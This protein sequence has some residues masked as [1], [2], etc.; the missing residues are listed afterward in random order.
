MASAA[1][2]VNANE[3]FSTS[4]VNTKW[5]VGLQE[6]TVTYTWPTTSP[7]LAVRGYPFGMLS[8][9]GLRAC[10]SSGVHY[11]SLVEGGITDI[12]TTSLGVF[13][14]LQLLYLDYNNLSHVKKDWFSTLRRPDALVVLSLSHNKIVDIESESFARLGMLR[15]MSLEHNR[16]RNLH[17]D[18]FYG[19][20]NLT[21]LNLFS[22]RLET[23]TKTAFVFLT[24]LKQLNMREN[25]LLNLPKGF[26]WPQKNPMYLLTGTGLLGARDPTFEWRGVVMSDLSLVQISVSGLSTYSTH[27]DKWFRYE[28]RTR[29]GTRLTSSG[30]GIG[31]GSLAFSQS[32]TMEEQKYPAPFLIIA[33]MEGEDM[34]SIEKMNYWCE[35]FWAGEGTVSVTLGASKETTVQLAAVVTKKDN[36]T[37]T[38]ISVLFNPAWTPDEE[39][40]YVNNQKQANSTGTRV[41]TCVMLSEMNK[42]ES[43]FVP[44][45][46]ESETV[47]VR[48]NVS[49]QSWNN[50]T[51][52]NKTNLVRDGEPIENSTTFHSPVDVSLSLRPTETDVT[53]TVR[54]ELP[55]QDEPVLSDGMIFVIIAGI[56]LDAVVTTFVVRMLVKRRCPS[57]RHDDG[58][59]DDGRHDY[60]NDYENTDISHVY[61][62][63]PDV[64]AG[65]PP[66][67]VV[68][69]TRGVGQASTSG[70]AEDDDSSYSEIPDDYF[71]FN[72]P[73]YRY[74]RNSLPPDD[75]NYWQILDEFYGY[76][77]TDRLANWRPSSLPLTFEA[78]YENAKY[79]NVGRWQRQR[80]DID[81]TPMTGKVGKKAG[82]I[83]RPIN[84]DT[85]SLANWRPSS[86]PLTLEATYENVK[87]ENVGRWSRQPSAVARGRPTTKRQRSRDVIVIGGYG[88]ESR[89]STVESGDQ[90]MA[91]RVGWRVRLQER[92]NISYDVAKRF[93]DR[94]TSAYQS[95]RRVSVSTVESG[96][97]NM[98][99]RV[100]WRVRLQ[101]RDNTSYDVAKRFSDR[102]TSAYQTPRVSV[103]SA[104]LDRAL[105]KQ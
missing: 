40:S 63:I 39:S 71:S 78:T 90:N 2:L 98:A 36:D 17:P 56:F 18:W 66:R 95:P 34:A 86:L 69:D 62:E 42:S 92:D 102:R 54:P 35:R 76:E 25:E 80:S 57:R 52:V 89:S 68:S 59:H 104:L 21:G 28:T 101:E 4:S 6:S 53:V 1:G 11:L 91:A 97:Q 79:E 45:R 72:N 67:P 99:A 75:H 46:G 77:N 30:F 12:E 43:Y 96:G 26:R 87:Y 38:L 73:G 84:E 85:E 103:S 58:R 88:T 24:E 22:N 64:L 5:S 83:G 33:A 8:A 41:V 16:L 13:L 37:T 82:A 3:P 50:N 70:T 81:Y 74:Q 20:T 49:D 32:Y 7:L 10:N 93:S 60:E 105:P 9:R 29:D 48:H 65:P 100:G 61:H 31:Y 14:D 94:R 44:K 15:M 27:A 55:D 23:L 51:A 19:L 47:H